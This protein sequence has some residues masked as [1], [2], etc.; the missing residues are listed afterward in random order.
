MN[1][2]ATIQ[3]AS[4]VGTLI[5]SESGGRIGRLTW[6]TAQAV[7][8][9]V[10][11]AEAAKQLAAYFDGRLRKFDLPLAPAGTAF[12]QDVYRAMS[13]IP[14]GATRSYGEIARALGSVARAV[15]QACGSNPIPILIPCHRVLGAGRAIG[16]FSGGRGTPTKRELL[17]HEGV[18]S[19]SLGF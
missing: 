5:V 16:G 19:L 15:G 6:G 9:T 8:R 3:I 1:S 2:V 7:E 14:Y 18:L 13:E 12:Q 11:L 17:A 10:L 4:P